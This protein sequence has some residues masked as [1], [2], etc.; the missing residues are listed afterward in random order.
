MF[1]RF[2]AAYRVDPLTRSEEQNAAWD[3]GVLRTAAGYAPFAERFGG[4]SF[5]HGAYRVH[6]AVTEP[7]ARGWIAAAFARHADVAPFG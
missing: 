7:G 2:L 3:D 1:E 6:D 4:R 5:E